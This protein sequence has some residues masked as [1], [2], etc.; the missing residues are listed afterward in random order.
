MQA[1][2]RKRKPKHPEQQSYNRG[3]KET[4]WPNWMPSN[5]QPGESQKEENTAQRTDRTED[6]S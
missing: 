4:A 5:K 2:K 1:K 6:V 3:R